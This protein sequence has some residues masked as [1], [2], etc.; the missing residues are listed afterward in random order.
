[1]ARVVVVGGGFAGMSAAARL[2]KL[3]HDVTILES[4]D[5]LGGRLHGVTH[6]GRTWPLDL[7]T[8]TLPGVFR[9]LFRKSGR[10]MEQVLELSMTQGR[11]HVF[12]DRSVLDLP[13]GSRGAQHRAVTELVGSDE[14]SPWVDGLADQWDVVRRTA[15]DQPLRGRD[16]VDRAARRTLHPRRSVATLAER[17]LSD[18]RLRKLVLDP[19][20]LAGQDRRATPGFVALGHYVERTFGRWRFAG[21]LPALSAALETR[22]AERA[23]SVELGESAHELVLEAGAVRGV[24][25]SARTVPADIVVWCAPTRPAPLPPVRLMPVIPASRT[26]LSLSHDAPDLPGEILVHA[27][28]P[29]RLWTGGPGLWTIEHRSGEDPLRALSRSGI[30]LRP[31]VLQQVDLNPSELVALGHWGWEWRGW[32]SAFDVPGVG[33]T[34]GLHFAGAHAHPGATLEAIGMATAAIA[35]AIGPAPR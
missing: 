1:M 29:I 32:T 18:D 17:D 21:G 12:K 23:V 16:A 10:P 15:L 3:R 9:D 5:R 20:R 28:P 19:V 27:N 2:A 25:T 26:L 31:Y 11:R 7:D 13:L 6:G 30:D 35:D 22:L 4:A 34:G 14:W 8:V 24:V 33:A